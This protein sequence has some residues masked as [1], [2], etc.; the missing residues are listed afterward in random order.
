VTQ[1]TEQM[2]ITLSRNC[3]VTADFYL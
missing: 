3:K 2:G 1:C